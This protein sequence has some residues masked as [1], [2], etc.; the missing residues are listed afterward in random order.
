MLT[1]NPERGA[2]A[3]A[4]PSGTVIANFFYSLVRKRLAHRFALDH[5]LDRVR[6]EWPAVLVDVS[7]LFQRGAYPAQRH[8][9]ASL[10]ARPMKTLGQ[11]HGCGVHLAM[12]LMAL[13]L[14]ASCGAIAGTS[15]GVDLTNS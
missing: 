5:A 4:D 9:L 6:I 8:A 2:T 12:G 14:A 3:G 15:A 13:T 10:G 11:G 7:C 1:A